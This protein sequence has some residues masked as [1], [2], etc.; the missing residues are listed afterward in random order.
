MDERKKKYVCFLSIALCVI[1]IGGLICL[2]ILT[3]PK[4]ET[5][6]IIVVA[7]QSNAE[8]VAKHADLANVLPQK[9]YLQYGKGIK[10]VKIIN[11][12]SLDKFVDF[13][14]GLNED[15]VTFGIEVGIIDYF[16]DVTT[17][18]KLFVVKCAVGGTSISYWQKGQEGYTSL[19]ETLNRAIALIG[20]K[21]KKIN[22]KAICWMQGESDR[23]AI[24]GEMYYSRLNSFVSDLRSDF[25]DYGDLKFIDAA[26]QNSVCSDLVNSNKKRFAETNSNNYYFEVD[27]LN[28]SISDGVHYDAASE[29]KLGYEFGKY[30]F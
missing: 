26:V 7:G 17:N 14:F 20:K 22:I 15:E 21:Y 18:E 6:N 24:D 8:G 5:A 27:G 16:L 13:T 4:N 2:R 30:C 12:Y 23:N 1:L 11:R 28:L 19:N 10:R 3:L 25:K 29:Y 9:R